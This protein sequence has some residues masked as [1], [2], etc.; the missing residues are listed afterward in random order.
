MQASIEEETI[1]GFPVDEFSD[2]R[3]KIY[4]KFAVKG[5]LRHSEII[6]EIK[7]CDR[8]VLKQ[9]NKDKLFRLISDV[10]AFRS[11]PL[12]QMVRCLVLDSESSC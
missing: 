3:I 11:D 5:I 10:G 1:A 8:T 12:S 4:R 9:L 2:L 6:D 7:S